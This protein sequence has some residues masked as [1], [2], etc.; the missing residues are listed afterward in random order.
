MEYT[1]IPV[2]K[3]SVLIPGAGLDYGTILGGY[4]RSATIDDE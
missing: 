3:N 1:G 4:Y 2:V